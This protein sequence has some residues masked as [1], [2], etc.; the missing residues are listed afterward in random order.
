MGD[1]RQTDKELIGAAFDEWA[2]GVGG[3]FA[4]LAE[5]ATWTITGNSPVSRTFRSRQEFLDVVIDPFNARM[6]ERLVPSVRGLFADG[7]WVIALFDAHATA[8]DGTP[9]DNTYSWYMR[10][11]GEGGNRRIVEAIAFFDTIEF[12]DFWKRVDPA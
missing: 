7:D 6:S 5:D 11:A 4:L 9:Y 3:P 10:L 1:E 8:R 2:A 12:T